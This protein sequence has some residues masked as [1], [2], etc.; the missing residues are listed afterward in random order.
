M[1]LGWSHHKNQGWRCQY[2]RTHRWFKRVAQIGCRQAQ[3]A[4]MEH[5]HDV[6]Y[7]FFQNCYHLRDWLRNSGAVSQKDL[8][9]FFNEH[10]DLRVCQDLC[11][12]TKHLDLNRP[13]VD[14]NFSIGREYVYPLDASD[15][16][17]LTERW[18]VIAGGEKYDLFDLA[19][20]CMSYWDGFVG[21]H[22]LI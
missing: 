6:L 11:N 1:G 15:R 17:H 10:V 2:N 19:R 12:G 20:R 18:F 8:D 4:D 21:R 3:A 9:E 7:A 16:P 14:A 22:G 13:K 5:E